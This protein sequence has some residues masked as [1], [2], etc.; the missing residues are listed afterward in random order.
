MGIQSRELHSD[1]VNPLMGMVHDPPHIFL[2]NEFCSRGALKDI[3][4]NDDFK[5]DDMF[6]TSI[7]NDL[8]K[9]VHYL[10]NGAIGFH[11]RLKSSNCLV[12]SRWLVESAHC[13][14]YTCIEIRCA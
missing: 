13:D 2:V 12:D 5:L 3:L 11:G 7:L 14:A 8:I 6:L 9:G 10:H 1:N 4:E